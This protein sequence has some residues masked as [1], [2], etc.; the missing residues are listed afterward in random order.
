MTPIYVLT[1]ENVAGQVRDIRELL[2]ALCAG[3][4]PTQLNWQPDGGRR[5]SV[6]QC[7]DHVTKTTYLYNSHLEEAVTGAPRQ[8][9]PAAR[10]NV[11]GRAFIWMIEPPARIR[12]RAPQTV[13]PSF[14]FDLEHLLAEATGALAQLQE[15]TSRTVQVDSGRLRFANPFLRGSRVFNV[16][17]GVLVM[18]AHTRRH[19]IQAER[20]KAMTDFPS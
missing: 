8:P 20:V 9:T 14:S 15:L 17:T 7:L 1:E 19:L 16:A 6:G 10:P 4:S 3:L 13:Q 18:L 2:D 12:V 5:W 11:L